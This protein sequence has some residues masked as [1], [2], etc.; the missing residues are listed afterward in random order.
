M[1]RFQYTALDMSGKRLAGVLNG[2]N[3]QAVLAELEG[4]SLVPVQ[5]QEKP[6]RASLGRK[7]LS[8]RRLAEVYIQLADMLQAGVP[9]LRALH[10]LAGQKDQRVATVFREV[11]TAVSEGDELGEAMSR[12]PDIFKPTHVAIIRAGEK[13][14]FLE[15]AMARLGQ[16]VETQ[17]E[18][19]SKLTGSM[20]YPL[21]L[22][23]MGGVILVVIFAVMI[24]KVRPMFDRIEQL[25]AVTEMVF[26]VANVA[27]NYAPVVFG[28]AAA[29]VVGFVLA[30]RKP[31]VQRAAG[32]GDAAVP[33]RGPAGA[34]DRG[35]AVCAHAGDDD[36]Q[37]RADAG[38]A[39]DG[40]G[41]R[42]ATS[43][44]RRR[45]S[46]RARKWGPASRWRPRWASP[47]CS[48]PT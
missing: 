21:V 23:G 45:S 41:P 9:V 1:P 12:R 2:Q 27:S 17:A 14:G 46:R 28:V 32:P 7:G 30:K 29:C 43:S 40:R 20:V 26:A 16:F 31:A 13:G 34:V 42:R 44:W 33:R 37:R 25:P 39:G 48:R 24:P 15:D 22:V 38:G 11:A 19:R 6:E 10:V 47:G 4:R 3:E 35:G 8:A 18:L 5:I 36:Q